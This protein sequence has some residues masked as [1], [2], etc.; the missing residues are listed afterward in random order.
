M[1]ILCLSYFITTVTELKYEMKNEGNDRD[2]DILIETFILVFAKNIDHSICLFV[3]ID[4]VIAIYEKVH[5]HNEP[6]VRIS[7]GNYKEKTW[8][9]VS[10]IVVL[11]V[12]NFWNSR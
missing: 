6:N 1:L 2:K 10:K 5:K 12:K 4:Y 3:Y 9:F 11:I 8:Y 7:F